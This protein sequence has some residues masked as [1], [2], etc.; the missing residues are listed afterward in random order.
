MINFDS[1]GLWR[2]YWGAG[3]LPH[4]AIALGTITRSALETGALLR[5]EA[6]GLYV[7]GNAGVIRL[8]PQD[9]VRAAIR[10]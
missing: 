1:K 8:L 4:K 3:P 10:K 9:E 5:F 7:Q 2:L 6:T